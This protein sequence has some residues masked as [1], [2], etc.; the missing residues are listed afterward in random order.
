MAYILIS[1][2]FSLGRLFG[3][4]SMVFDNF[5]VIAPVGSLDMERDFFINRFC[6]CVHKK[7]FL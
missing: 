6:S 4:F 3:V 1:E 5:S 2:V 7:F